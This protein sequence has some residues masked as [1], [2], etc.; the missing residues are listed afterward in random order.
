MKNEEGLRD[1]G[2]CPSGAT[3]CDY[4]ETHE[5]PLV[6]RVLQSIE[7]YNQEQKAHPCPACLRDAMLAV[8]A[9]LHLEAERLLRSTP[10]VSRLEALEEEFGETAREKFR[11]VALAAAAVPLG[12]RQ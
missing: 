4:S 3:E 9:L 2:S 12:P 1:D 6:R 8:A 7:Q 11:S 10:A 5:M